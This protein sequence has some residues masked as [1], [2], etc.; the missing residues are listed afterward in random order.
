MYDSTLYLG[1]FLTLRP[2]SCYLLQVREIIAESPEHHILDVVAS[3]LAEFQ[4]L[5]L[6]DLSDGPPLLRDIQH[7][8]DFITGSQLSNLP[9]YRMNPTE[10]VELK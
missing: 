3:I 9:H 8:I 1:N 5:Y 4:Y 7:A 2:T 6:D 10:H